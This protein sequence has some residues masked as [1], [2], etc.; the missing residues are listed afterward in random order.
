MS[1]VIRV[2]SA[3]FEQPPKEHTDVSIA[4]DAHNARIC[5]FIFVVSPVFF[6]LVSLSEITA[7]KRSASFFVYPN[8]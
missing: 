4:A 7:G 5:F 8:A 3:A 2:F 6:D 1:T